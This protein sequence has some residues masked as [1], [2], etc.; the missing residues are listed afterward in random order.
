MEV[1]SVFKTVSFEVGTLDVEI[2]ILSMW[3]ALN[4]LEQRSPRLL[5]LWGHAVVKGRIDSWY[6]HRSH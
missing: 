6:R 5:R 4:P 3:I 2:T 1:I